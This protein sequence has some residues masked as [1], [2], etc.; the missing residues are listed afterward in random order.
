MLRVVEDYVGEED[1][2]ELVGD[3]E[4]FEEGSDGGAPCEALGASRVSGV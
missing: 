4:G 2:I 1:E 3:V